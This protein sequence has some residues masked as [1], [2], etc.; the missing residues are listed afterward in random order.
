MDALAVK[1][2]TAFA[3]AYVVENGPLVM[4]MVGFSIGFRS[5]GNQLHWCR[6][7]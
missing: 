7:Q 1:Q 2:A 6:L 3:K 4:E 5:V